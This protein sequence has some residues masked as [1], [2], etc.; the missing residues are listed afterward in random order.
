MNCCDGSLTYFI[1]LKG[2]SKING[3]ACSLLAVCNYGLLLKLSL[4]ASLTQGLMHFNHSL[5]F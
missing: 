1:F 3:P 2:K 5:E 4:I